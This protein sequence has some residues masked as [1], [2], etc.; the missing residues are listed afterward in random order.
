MRL[1][2]IW[3]SQYSGS[4]FFCTVHKFVV[5]TILLHLSL[6]ILDD[7]LCTF[8]SRI[9]C[10]GVVGKIHIGDGVRKDG[11]LVSRGSDCGVRTEACDVDA[12][13]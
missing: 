6:P 5:I 11:T 9:L 4:I 1:G 7:A 13:T 10:A 12:S 2:S 8:F 3:R